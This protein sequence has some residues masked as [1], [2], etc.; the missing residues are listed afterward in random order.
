MTY[1]ARHQSHAKPVMTVAQSVTNLT[2]LLV[3]CTDKR[4]AA[5]TAEE[6]ASSYRVSPAMAAKL[7]DAQRAHRERLL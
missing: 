6:L 7:L 4:L 2:L 3:G 1:R 5:M